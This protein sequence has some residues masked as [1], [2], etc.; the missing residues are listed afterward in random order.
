VELRSAVVVVTGASSGIGRATATR[1]ARQGSDVVVSARRRDRLD[2][3]AGE[4]RSLG[5]RAL[6][7]EC[8]VGEWPQ[9]RSLA[10]AT[11]NEFGRADVLVNNAGVLGAARSIGSRSRMPSV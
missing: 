7:V 8:D 1:F 5:R 4:I 11:M 6:V 10:E 2:E 3:L 9:V